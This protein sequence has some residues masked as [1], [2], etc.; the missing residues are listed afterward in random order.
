MRIREAA[1]S[2]FKEQHVNPKLLPLK[3]SCRVKPLGPTLLLAVRTTAERWQLLPHPCQPQSMLARAEDPWPLPM[4]SHVEQAATP[5][6]KQE[7][8]GSITTCKVQVP[9]QVASAA[10]AYPVEGSK[11]CGVEPA[12]QAS[13]P[14]PSHVAVPVSI[15][16]L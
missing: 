13:C 12:T 8:W 14:L 7:L 4:L 2:T 16:T 11:E 6:S 10:L 1:T 3:L 5:A 9:L 15:I